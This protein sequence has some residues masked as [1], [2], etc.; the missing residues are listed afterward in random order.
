MAGRSV[1]ERA[2]QGLPPF[3]RLILPPLPGRIPV[4][5][6]G[7]ILWKP[8]STHLIARVRSLP[9]KRHARHFAL[10]HHERSE[11]QDHHTRSGARTE[12]FHVARRGLWRRGF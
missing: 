10:E 11:K 9:V 1:K 2:G 7:C 3:K 6:T 5:A 8:A 12:S 4:I